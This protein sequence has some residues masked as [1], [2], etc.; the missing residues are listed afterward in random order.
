MKNRCAYIQYMPN[1]RHARFGVKKF[2]LVDSKTMYVIHIDMYSGKD[3]LAEEHAPFTQ[4]VVMNLLEQGG[5]IYKGYHVFTDNFY[6]KLPLAQLLLDNNTFLTGTVNKNSKDLSKSVLRTVLGPQKSV[7]FRR[8]PVLL[9]GYK[10]KP[11]RKPVYL[12][13]T[14]YHA[15]DRVIRSRKS[16][17]EAIKPVL[18]DKYNQLMGG[19]DCKDKSLYHWSCTRI[20]R[21]YWKK[22]FFNLLDMCVSNAYVVY[23]HQ[24]I[25]DAPMDRK[26]LYPGGDTKPDFCL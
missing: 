22:L 3:H 24:C 17:L 19:V 2:E 9:V 20:T 14:A 25:P 16:G 13:S 15:E 8:G 12:I 7:Y 5:C 4:K 1:K 21:R 26:K 18:I 11:T 6:T 23:A 10:Q